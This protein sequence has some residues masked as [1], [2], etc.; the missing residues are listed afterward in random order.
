M[1]FNQ[2]SGYLILVTKKPC[3]L[4][5][6]F[7]LLLWIKTQETIFISAHNSEN[8]DHMKTAPASM[9]SRTQHAEMDIFTPC[10]LD[11]EDYLIFNIL[12][13]AVQV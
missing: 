7:L 6:T 10:G 2:F 5:R 1:Y 4:V 11:T 3:D 12:L 9:T 13:S 8:N